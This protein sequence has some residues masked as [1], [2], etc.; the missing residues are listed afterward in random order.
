MSE[1]YITHRT[2]PFIPYVV[3]CDGLVIPMG[4][5]KAM[6][7]AQFR[8]EDGVIAELKDSIAPAS[9][10][11]YIKALDTVHAVKVCDSWIIPIIGHNS[12]DSYYSKNVIFTSW[13]AAIRKNNE[14]D[15]S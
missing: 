1:M 13:A 8:D 11:I 7:V 10:V 15:N 6:S 5:I 9:D 4:I 2:L 3:T 14:S 12:Y